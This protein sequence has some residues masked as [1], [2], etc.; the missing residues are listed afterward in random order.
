MLGWLFVLL[1]CTR[2]VRGRVGEPCEG[3]TF[4]LVRSSTTAFSGTMPTL[5]KYSPD[6]RYLAMDRVRDIHIFDDAREVTLHELKGHSATITDLQFSS[7]GLWLYSSSKASRKITRSR[8]GMPSRGPCIRPWHCL[9][10]RL[11]LR[12]LRAQAQCL[13]TGCS[14]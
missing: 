2:L 4:P 10:V 7:D 5:L 1:L 8:S 11:R 9:W 13:G 14:R 12:S 6:G 3:R